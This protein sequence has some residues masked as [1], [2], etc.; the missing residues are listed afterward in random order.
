MYY[1]RIEKKLG[2]NEFCIKKN[3]LRF[4]YQKNLGLKKKIRNKRVASFLGSP[5][6]GTWT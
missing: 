5:H 3:G 6:L 4:S 2:L 1:F